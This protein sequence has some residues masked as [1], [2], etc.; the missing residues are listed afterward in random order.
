MEHMGRSLIVSLYNKT[1]SDIILSKNGMIL[2]E[3]VS[4]DLGSA[5]V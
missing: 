3:F 4:I 5:S 1:V 2:T